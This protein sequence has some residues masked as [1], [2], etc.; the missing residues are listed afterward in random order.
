MAETQ[1]ILHLPTTTS[2]MDVAAQLVREGDTTT[3]AVMAD[4]QTAGRGRHNRPWTTFPAPHSLAVTCIVRPVVAAH[5]PLIA[6]LSLHQALKT[7]M[8][9]E[10]VAALSIKWPNDILLSGQ[11]VAGILCQNINN[12]ASLIGMGVNLTAP[13]TLPYTFQGT[14]L[15]KLAA[16]NPTPAELL[17]ILTPCLLNNIALYNQHGW[18]QTLH[19]SYL[20]HCTT[21]GQNVRW[22]RA[23]NTELTG[24]ARG[25]NPSGHLEMVAEDGTVHV[26]HSGE[27]FEESQ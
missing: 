25:L 15:A 9:S 5:L 24:Q 17:E 12:S 11:K 22:Q 19:D 27:I 21:I 1:A 13:S 7:F 18:S 3:F 2:T 23:D 8:K 16:T 20:R 6:A 14:F 4:E 26:I 10:G